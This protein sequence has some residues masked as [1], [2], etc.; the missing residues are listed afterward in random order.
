MRTNNS[1]T[2]WRTST[3]Y[4]MIWASH[5]KPKKTSPSA[6]SPPS[7]AFL[8]TS[9]TGRSAYQRARRRNTSRPSWTGSQNQSTRWTMHKSCTG[10]YYTP[11]TSFLLDVRTSPTWRPSWEYATVT[12]LSACAPHPAKLWAIFSG[13]KRDSPNLPSSETSPDPSPLLMPT[14][15]R[16]LA[17][18]LVL[19]SRW[20]TDGEPGG[21]YRGGKPIAGTSGGQK[22]SDAGSSS[23]CS[24]QPHPEALTPR[25]SGTTEELSR[26]GGKA[27]AGTNPPTTYS[28][29]SMPSLKRKTS[30]STRDTSPAKKIQLMVHRAE[31]TSTGPSS[32]QPS[33]SPCCSDYTY[34][35][36]THLSHQL[37]C[38][39]FSR[40]KPPHPSPG[41]IAFHSNKNE[42]PSTLLWKNMPGPSSPR[43]SSGSTVSHF[44]H[45]VQ[46][47]PKPAKPACYCKGSMPSP[48]CQTPACSC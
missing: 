26:V 33:P 17:L 48:I 14:L 28:S 36:S 7:L 1:H 46:H 24:H 15:T 6:S 8:G 29:T 11:A 9:S 31:N 3:P 12:A 30:V 44:A 42:Q 45:A 47:T 4:P 37:S 34:A 13:G 32:F 10:S 38:S 18:R 35:T 23:S 19:G 16:M 39:F 43:H 22:Q 21:S 40:G 27:E 20:A 2:A 25:F 41:L 5:G